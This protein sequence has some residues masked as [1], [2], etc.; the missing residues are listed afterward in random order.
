MSLFMSVIKFIIHFL[1]IAFILL[2][3][4]TT[5]LVDLTVLVLFNGV[6]KINKELG[7][8]RNNPNAVSSEL[9]FGKF[10]PSTQVWL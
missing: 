5:R 1:G 9:V 8:C 2:L 6:V 7:Y 4:S 3:C 10:P